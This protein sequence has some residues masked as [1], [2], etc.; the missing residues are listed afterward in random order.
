MRYIIE[1]GQWEQSQRNST[2]QE[3]NDFESGSSINEFIVVESDKNKCIQLTEITDPSATSD[4][5]FNL[6][7]LVNSCQATFQEFSFYEYGINSDQMWKMNGYPLCSNLDLS[8]YPSGYSLETYFN[9]LSNISNNKGI[10]F[11]SNPN[12]QYIL[13]NYY[14]D[15]FLE[16]KFNLVLSSYKM[17]ISNSYFLNTP[18]IKSCGIQAPSNT[19]GTSTNN[20]NNTDN[21]NNTNIT[22]NINNTYNTKDSD[23]VINLDSDV[24]NINDIVAKNITAIVTDP[25]EISNLADIIDQKITN[26]KLNITDISNL[27]SS[28]SQVS[29]KISISFLI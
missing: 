16:K 19:D 11:I 17:K 21:N 27:Q 10:C 7:D 1:R 25:K 13:N 28:L 18:E 3:I 8:I 5:N 12:C 15:T 29:S 4:I 24:E 26:G 14:I 20:N 9:K 6:S 23:T 22:D 2:I